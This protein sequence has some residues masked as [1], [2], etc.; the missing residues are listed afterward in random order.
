MRVK[1]NQSECMYGVAAQVVRRQGELWSTS[2]LLLL[3]CVCVCVGLSIGVCKTIVSL[4]LS[5]VSHRFLRN[6]N[7]ILGVPSVVERHVVVDILLFG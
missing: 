6:S 2:V 5:Q 1:K 4:L 3:C 7:F